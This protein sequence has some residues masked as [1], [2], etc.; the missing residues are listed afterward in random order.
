MGT[1]VVPGHLWAPEWCPSTYEN[2]M[3]YSDIFRYSNYTQ[4]LLCP[5]IWAPE[6]CPETYAHCEVARAQIGMRMVPKHIWAPQGCPGTNTHQ[7]GAH[8][9]ANICW[10]P[11]WCLCVPKHHCCAYMRRGT[12]KVPGEIWELEWCP[13]IYE[14]QNGAWAH[15]GTGCGTRA[16]MDTIMILKHN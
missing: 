15:I 8:M 5:A 2:W 16:N 10:A 3:W 1:G 12:R 6:G 13:G 4:A 14:H 9:G 11:F 7:I